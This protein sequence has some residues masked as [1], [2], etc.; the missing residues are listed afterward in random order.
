MTTTIAGFPVLVDRSGDAQAWLDKYLPTDDIFRRQFQDPDTYL[1]GPRGTGEFFVSSLPDLPPIE[2]GQIQWPCVG[3]SRFARGLFLV[4]RVGLVDILREA[5]GVDA[6]TTFP[7][8]IPSSWLQTKNQTVAVTLE[9]GV[10]V[11]L[12]VLLPIRVSDDVWI[13]PLVD[14]RYYGLGQPVKV[15]AINEEK[16]SATW[17]QYFTALSAFNYSVAYSAESGVSYGNPDPILRD[18]QVALPFAIDAA[19]FSLGC[20]PVVPFPAVPDQTQA[21]FVQTVK[22]ELPADAIVKK[23]VLFSMDK[24]TG[25]S[26]GYATKPLGVRFA[27]RLIN[28]YY[29]GENRSY[30]YDQFIGSGSGEGVILFAKALWNVHLPSADPYTEFQNYTSAIADKLDYWNAD[31]Y[32][33]TLLDLVAV[34]PSGFDDYIVFDTLR[35]T[36]TV[37][38]LPVDFIAP[39]FVSQTPAGNESVEEPTPTLWFHTENQIISAV[40]LSN[41]AGGYADEGMRQA[42]LGTAQI[43]HSAL[44]F[45]VTGVAYAQAVVSILNGQSSAIKTG[46]LIYLQWAD[47]VVGGD[48]REGWVVSG[49]CS[50]KLEKFVM[51]SGWYGGIAMASFTLADETSID[52]TGILEDPMGIFVD[53]LSIGSVGW[54]MR[55]CRGRH[56]VIQGKCKQPAVPPPAPMGRCIYGSPGS[57]DCSYTTEANCN[58]VGGTWDEGVPCS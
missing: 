7:Y 41:I 15:T 10:V 47:D 45:P 49:P 23:A 19:C 20:R 12:F 57:P 30:T 33:I 58:L 3:V 44:K 50:E 21:A 42:T 2:I 22:C 4:D 16:P 38:S 48:A 27:T 18:P 5:W 39:Y 8:T 24:V 6:P 29:S 37:R 34:D 31:E 17:A 13:L 14:G 36:T 28:S 26:S 32:Y 54:S 40:A 46:D 56:F 25:G 51:L 52:E 11:H 35:K 43:V 55:T 53:Q 1:S 9:T